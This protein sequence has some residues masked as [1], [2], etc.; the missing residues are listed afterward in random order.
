MKNL[1]NIECI[2]K[3]C[4]ACR[5]CEMLCPQHAIKLKENEE[6]FIYP[7]VDEKK[8][9]NC[10][11]CLNRCHINCDNKNEEKKYGIYAIKPRNVEISKK[12]TS[13][14]LAYIISSE[15]INRN[16]IVYGASYDYN[17]CVRHIKVNKIE[18]L[19]YIRGSKYV[20]SDVNYT[21]RNVK[22]D[23]ESGYFVLYTGTPCQIAGLKKFLNKDYEKLITMDIVCHGV[24]SQKLFLKYIQFLEEKTNEKIIKFD[25]RNK[26]KTP[27]GGGYCAKIE[28][29]K[30]TKKYLRAD[31][32][33]YYTN[34]LQGNSFLVFYLR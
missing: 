14:G 20:I 16:G 15:I 23:L 28:T 10:G 7:F 19:E 29:N 34:F 12:S 26:D 8:C 31:F 9:V 21:F 2:D 6:G 17:L 22:S 4:T 3:K 1:N 13:A 5:T 33:P 27:W 24:P 30:G 32:D 11:L 25:F 18:H